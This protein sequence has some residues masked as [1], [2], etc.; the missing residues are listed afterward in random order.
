MPKRYRACKDDYMAMSSAETAFGLFR[1]I[2]ERLKAGGYKGPFFAD[3]NNRLYKELEIVDEEATRAAQEA[4]NRE[5]PENPQPVDPV[6]KTSNKD[7]YELMGE[8]VPVIHGDFRVEDRI[9]CSNTLTSAS[10][11]KFR[12]YLKEY[13]NY[14][15]LIIKNTP[16]DEYAEELE[17]IK[18]QKAYLR[19]LDVFGSRNFFEDQFAFLINAKA[20]DADLPPIK[21]IGNRLD[22]GVSRELFRS[23]VN[24]YP[25][26]EFRTAM[27]NLITDA[28]DYET[29]AEKD[30]YIEQLKARE[31]YRRHLI[32]YKNA[33]KKLQS[34]PG[35]MERISKSKM[36]DD[37]IAE[38]KQADNRQKVNIDYEGIIK[39]VEKQQRLGQNVDPNEL[40]IVNDIN[41]RVNARY[42]ERK[43]YE[44]YQKF[45][46]AYHKELL[47]MGYKTNEMN[48]TGIRGSLDYL[49]EVDAQINAIDMGWPMDELIHIERFLIATRSFFSDGGVQNEE[50]LQQKASITTFYNTRIKDQPYPT[51]EEGRRALYQELLHYSNIIVDLSRSTVSDNFDD[52]FDIQWNEIRD[53]IRKSMNKQLTF[54]EKLVLKHVRNDHDPE[55]TARN[56]SAIKNT[57]D[58]KRSGHSNSK[59]YDKFKSAFDRF[60]VAFSE[61]QAPYSI[62]PGQTLNPEALEI[63][64]S[65]RDNSAH[66]LKEKDKEK[67]LPS[68]RSRMGQG[69][70]EGAQK[71]YRI[72]DKL[73]KIHE[74]TL[75][76]AAKRES[77]IAKEKGRKETIEAFFNEN[78]NEGRDAIKLF[79]RRAGG[80]ENYDQQKAAE[81]EQK[82][83]DLNRVPITD[84]EKYEKFIK[85]S[86]LAKDAPVNDN[87]PIMDSELQA[88]RVSQLAYMLAAMELKQEGEPFNKKAIENR[89]SEIRTIY[90]LDSLTHSTANLNG[91]E[92]L[93]NA[94]TYQFRALDTK[95]MLEESLYEVG[96]INYKKL[97]TRNNRIKNTSHYNNIYK[98]QVK[99]KADIA[100]L[101]KRERPTG[102]SEN[103][104]TIIDALNE[105]NQI[106][107]DSKSLVGINSYKLRKANLKLIKAINKA[108]TV[109]G[110]PA[111]IDLNGYG[112]KLALDSL[113]V[114]NTYTNCKAVTNTILKRINLQIKDMNN[115]K[116]NISIPD[117]NSNYG[118]DHTKE[119]KRE[120]QAAEQAINNRPAVA[121]NA[122]AHANNGMQP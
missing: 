42:E 64:K 106:N 113:A 25:Y 56:I 11:K 115:N 70:Y 68:S 76:E 7:Y 107:L 73:I 110:G 29:N 10:E 79:E 75:E 28:C 86:S 117:F 6:Y 40:N 97:D 100:E 112:P 62:Q 104:Q 32:D 49:D 9:K 27:T 82:L 74:A 37:I 39:R 19:A 1:P 36:R 66:Y 17:E 91:P 46:S 57:I 109:K 26:S 63:L 98:S 96:N 35:E 122:H 114:L 95:K 34:A 44:E 108:F 87:D 94:L 111:R 31:I 65:L 103:T 23:V 118:V 71:A 33:L 21:E 60:E 51:T 55:M 48:I 85:E 50:R 67:K 90:S 5:H 101:L 102:I 88:F 24:N 12:K 59:E 53:D 16:A 2:E 30:T 72:A 116:I 61:N 89:V 18:F 15:D 41:N 54:A 52:V 69:R 45:N 8:A 22:N 93:K 58:I 84:E 105:I 4:E 77:E 14:L 3:F 83:A 47:A 20:L 78:S 80:K 120:I 38:K 121:H 92:K 119:I 81:A 43:L 13:T 99:F